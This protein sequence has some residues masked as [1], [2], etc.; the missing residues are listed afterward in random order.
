MADDVAITAGSGTT[1]AAD[2]RTINATAVKVQRI[3][4]QGGTAWATGQVTVTAAAA[5]LL[6]A[7]E[8]RKSATILNNSNVTIY[9]GPATV[10]VANGFALAPGAAVDIS[11]TGLLQQITS[12]VTGLTGVTCYSEVYDA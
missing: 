2:E 12:S 4:D 8:T 1:I 10:T 11:F 6:A 3:I 5:T 7:R 9:I